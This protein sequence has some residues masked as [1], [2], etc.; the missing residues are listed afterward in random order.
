M[1][2]LEDGGI[3]GME[4]FKVG[5]KKWNEEMVCKWILCV[6]WWEDVRELC[7]EV[8]LVV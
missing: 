6:V 8:G 5:C 7:E 4:I 2:I 1:E 3:I